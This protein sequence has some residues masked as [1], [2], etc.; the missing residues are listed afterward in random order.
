M[1]KKRIAKGLLE[2]RAQAA[3]L[4][5]DTSGVTADQIRSTYTMKINDRQYVVIDGA[6]RRFA[7]YR[8][9]SYDGFLRMLRRWPKELQ[10]FDPRKKQKSTRTFFSEE[11]ESSE[12]KKV[13]E[14][15]FDNPQ[16]SS[17][18]KKNNLPPWRSSENS[19]SRYVSLDHQNI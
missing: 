19:G 1:D 15:P 6:N 10:S 18:G 5:S 8:V 2:G 7:V 12:V 14:D 17:A 13:V 16:S 11:N 4:M 3:F 9:R